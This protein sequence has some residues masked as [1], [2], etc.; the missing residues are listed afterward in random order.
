MQAG[1]VRV[2]Q[3]PS[4]AARQSDHSGYYF[5]FAGFGA[6]MDRMMSDTAAVAGKLTIRG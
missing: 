2:E 4:R 5:R 6:E 3:R 1:A